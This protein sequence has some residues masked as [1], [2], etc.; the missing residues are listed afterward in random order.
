MAYS[1]TYT[2]ADLEPA[3]LDIVIGLFVAIAE[4]IDLI[5]LALAISIVVNLFSNAWSALT[6]FIG[7][8]QRLS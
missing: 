6:G 8:L 2:D 1:A 5:G 3:F 7:N 4:K